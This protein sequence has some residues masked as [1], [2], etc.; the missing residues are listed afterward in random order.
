MISS[1]GGKLKKS[2]NLDL[3]RTIAV[4]MVVISHIGEPLAWSTPEARSFF[5]V[6]GV[7][8]FFVHT[9]LVLMLSLD[10]DGGAA[11]PFLLRRFFRIYPLAVAM[12]I[13]VAVTNWLVGKS[14]D[15]G[16]VVSNM[17]LVQNVTGHDSDPFPL[18]SLPYEVQM[19]LVLPAIF[20]FVQVNGL[21]RIGALLVLSL[22]LI[23]SMAGAGINV[24]LVRYVPCFLPGVLAYV[25]ALRLRPRFGPAVLFVLVG[26]GSVVLA[27]LA[28]YAGFNTLHLYWVFSLLI[29]VMIPLCH[30][31][32]WRPLLQLS[33]IIAK[34]SY[35]IYLTHI[36]AVNFAFMVEPG[37]P[38][39]LQWVIF[40]GVLLAWIR[41]A[42]HWIEAP[43]IALGIR[44][45]ESI[46]TRKISSVT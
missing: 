25:L 1:A 4:V 21:L 5:G 12:V 15:L 3:L 37:L 16:Q 31:L 36:M 22:S 20:L 35:S 8:I 17:L 19:Y 39:S 42:H 9:S 29:G 44:L 11:A 14:L 45:S 10:R 41:V 40:S 23:V 30:D 28:L 2:S 34:Y 26:F 24:Y 33:S 27:A 6:L 38:R 18:W 13:V 43:G 46:R 7:T 32:T